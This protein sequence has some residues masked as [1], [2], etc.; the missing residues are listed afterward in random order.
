MGKEG[1]REYR[2]RVESGE[3]KG[4]EC[5][6]RVEWGEE[7][8]RVEEESGGGEGDECPEERKIIEWWWGGKVQCDVLY[9]VIG[10]W[11][12][13]HYYIRFLSLCALCSPSSVI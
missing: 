4:G 7:R 3:R 10:S 12:F 9:G 13:T 1:E 2:R 8:R 11:E 6:R 5:R